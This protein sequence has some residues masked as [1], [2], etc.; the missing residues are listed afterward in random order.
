MSSDPAALIREA[1]A[2]RQAGRLVEAETA[3]LRILDRWPAL[4]DCWFN[5]GVVQRRAGNFPAA[6]V[7]YQQALARGISAPEEVHLNRAVIY[8]K[9]DQDDAAESELR[10]A[11]KANP[12]YAPALLNLAN[13]HEDRG[14]RQDARALYEQV[15][16]LDPQC[17]LALARLANLHP[18]DACDER[19]IER[20]RAALRQPAATPADRA[21]LGFAL[22]RALDASGQYAAAFAAYEAANRDSRA[23]AMPGMPP[24]DRAAQERV[25]EQLIAT[26]LPQPLTPTSAGSPRPRPIF[27]CGMYRSGT[28][29]AEQLLA[30]HPEVAAGGELDL[31][32]AMI[33][34]E[35][36]PFPESLATTPRAKLERLAAA[37]RDRL[38]AAFPGAAH[39]TDKRPDNFFCI[40]LIKTLFPD[41]KIV[42]TTRDALDNCLSVFFLH[43]DP[44]LSY[45]LD[46]RDT[47]HFYRQYRRVMAHW[48]RVFGSDIV[49]FNYDEFVSAPEVAGPRLFERLDLEWN[50]RF[51]EWARSPG[52]VR[53]ASVWQVRE[54]LYQSSSGRARHYE[55][56]LAGLA[57]D[58]ADLP[59]AAPSMPAAMR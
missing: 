52:A 16:T 35:L 6:L 14:R 31:L 44:R 29:L 54:P 9:M 19:L 58:L 59:P 15:L 33:A 49:D 40:G 37:Y 12:S 39:V 3:Y 36:L 48:K 11:L 45:A 4:P 2:L 23:S 43:L 13:L 5:L 10:E 41:A 32:P 24:Y 30:G 38:A 17:F 50:P 7:S 21:D 46:L 26:P 47:G 56:E 20:L 18:P 53:T 8:A 1:N 51:L 28:T 25:T 27:V 22:G 55:R 57:R 34:S 42:H